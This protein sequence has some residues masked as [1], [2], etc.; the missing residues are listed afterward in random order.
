[1][2]TRA[3]WIRLFITCWMVFVLH[4][5]TDFGREHY[6]VLSIVEDFSFRLD[7][8]KGLH[9]DIFDTPGHGAH[10]A[11]NPGA[12]MVAAIPYFIFRPIVNTIV[13]HFR[14]H[15]TEQAVY[16]NPIP[17]RAEFYKQVRARGLDIKFGLVGLITMVFC[18]APLSALSAVVLFNALGRLGLSTIRSLQMALVYAVGT[19]IFFRTGYLNHNLMVGVFGFIA[20]VLLWQLDTTRVQKVS[21]RFAWAG[22]LAGLSLLCDY[23]GL[24]ILIL[25]GAYA[26]LKIRDVAPSERKR[27]NLLWYACGAAGPVALLWFY[28]WRSFGN[29]FYPPQHYMPAINPYVEVGYQG[30]RWDKELLWMLLFDARVGLFIASPILLL[31][32]LA[33]V[34]N[35]FRKNLIPL[36]E[37]ILI[38]ILFAA[39]L[40]FFSFVQFTRL[41]WIT[42]IRYLIPVIPF[43]FLLTVSV[44]VRLPRFLAYGLMLIAVVESWC[45]AMVRSHEG[46]S[47]LDSV[48]KVFLGGFQLPWMDTLSKMSFQ[49]A[50]FLSNTSPLPFFALWAVLLYGVW[51]LKDPW[52]KLGW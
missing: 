24:L 50:P 14:G 35:Y 10:H 30:I 13:A 43:V 16:N 25:L 3:I 41:Q 1:M 7:K 33:P 36:R 52:K 4:F 32:F 27:M 45:M 21:R 26:V 44:L 48:K 9:S 28:Q 20:F 47:V 34:L 18:M 22:F 12:S 42:G 29:P 2:T 19:P 40:I 37:T 49:Y 51:Y 46:I 6:L 17:A 11:G 38:L 5:A 23:S 15:N 39:F 8:Y 31:G